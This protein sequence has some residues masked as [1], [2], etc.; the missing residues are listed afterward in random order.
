[1]GFITLSDGRKIHV[2]RNRYPDNN[3][4]FWKDL[5]LDE[6]KRLLGRTHVSK[7]DIDMLAKRQWKS[8]SNSDANSGASN[9]SGYVN[10]QRHKFNSEN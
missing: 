4:Q 3:N 7:N 1:M 2:D 9:I 10:F 5:P 8:L 6:R